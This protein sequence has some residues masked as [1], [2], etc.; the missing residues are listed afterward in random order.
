MR[1]RAAAPRI[2]A[3]VVAAAAAASAA[4]GSLA[5]DRDLSLRDAIV[6]ALR[7][8]DDID[9]Q[10]EAVA[11]AE[12]AVMGA[13]GAYDPLLELQG[14]W[15]RAT[16]PV[17]SP[18]SGAPAGQPAPTIEI[19]D[20]AA[21]VRQLLP[22][23][24]EVSLRAAASRETTDSE[25]ALLSPS[26]ATRVG[27]ELRQPLLRNR[28]LDEAR[29][30]IRI[31]ASDR[32]R[33]G[34]G[35]RQVLQDAVADVERAYWDL[36]AARRAVTVQEEAVRLAEEQLA[37][38]SVRIE[39]G[40]SPE[41]EIAQPRAELERRR[42]ELIAARETVSRAQ[43][44]LKLRILDDRDEELWTE[45]LVP[46]E[47]MTAELQ[48]VDVAESLRRALAERPELAAAEAAIERRR[49]EASFAREGIRPALDAVVSYDRLGF[50]GSRNTGGDEVPG[51]PV[52]VPEGLEGGLGRSY[53]TLGEGEFDDARASLVFGFPI[54][55][56]AARAAALGARSAQRQAEADLARLRKAV[57]AEVLDAA[58]AIDT[59]GQRIQAA[60]AAREAAEVQLSSERDRYAAGLSTNFLVLTRQNDLSRAR[61]DEIAALTD[62]RTARAE[63]ARSTG[64]LLAERG[65]DI[66]MEAGQ[67]E[68]MDDDAPAEGSTRPGGRER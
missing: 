35:L 50:A 33:E 43:N 24:G 42:G 67:D 2:L 30:T 19:A 15:R 36:A 14:G 40:V 5:E 48:A 23:G 63:M 37:E 39:N 7:N 8:S 21:S 27:V 13:R 66:E 49:A 25:F 54:G 12:A 34:A 45:G 10:R 31:A 41:T 28:G 56:R 68:R 17:N 65:V 4:G 53:E 44:R 26:Y 18:F 47:E 58:A 55:N 16:E 38:T 60:R 57:R 52:V 46:S 3:S 11:A 62:Y 6:L 1:R 22:T 51:L 20:A 59:A 32:S 61:L 64:S 9:I 29:V